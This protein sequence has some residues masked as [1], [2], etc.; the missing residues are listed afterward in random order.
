[1]LAMLRHCCVS[2]LDHDQAVHV[3]GQS[4]IARE[5]E[6][7]IQTDAW[8]REEPALDAIELK[9]IPYDPNA[10]DLCLQYIDDC[11]IRCKQVH[12]FHCVINRARKLL[13]QICYGRVLSFRD[14]PPARNLT[15]LLLLVEQPDPD[16]DWFMEA[17]GERDEES[18]LEESDAADAAPVVAM[19]RKI[20]T[21]AIDERV[22]DIHL[23]PEQARLRR[24]YRI[25]GVLQERPAIAKKYA[26]PVTARLKILA[27]MD[28][29]ERRCPQDGRFT[30]SHPTGRRDLRVSSFPSVW[31]EK[32]VLR[33]LAG[34]GDVVSL[35]LLGFNE[36]SLSRY[37][38]AYTA[39]NGIIL[40]TGPTGSGKSSTLYATLSALQSPALSIVTLEDPVEARIEGITQGQIHARANFSFPEGLRAILRQDPD[41]I[42]V[43]EIRDPET[44]EIAMQASLTGHLVLSTLHTNDAASSV[45]RLLDMEVEPYLITATV[46]CVIAQRLGRR[47]CPTC[48]ELNPIDAKV[49]E[50]LYL[51]EDFIGTKCGARVGCEDC[52]E[53]GYTGRLGIF[54]VMLMD[55]A[56]RR[57]IIK[58]CNR[59]DVED[60]AILGGMCTMRLDGFGKSQAGLTSIDEVLRVT[61]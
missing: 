50:E 45:T 48:R 23:E 58:G 53:T 46:H 14:E 35:E 26:R 40:V 19:V 18:D 13:Q 56:M 32:M 16:T 36:K 59:K 21:E 6:E 54:E 27:G 2:C 8:L 49:V 51:E 60:L 57:E 38:G 52:R 7:A 24:R 30:V 31:G 10:V 29:A 5:I 41:V 17:E 20:V 12:D 34:K 3:C 11:C 37:R 44:A 42:M 33:V 4:I 55:D 9:S 47:L 43:G 61:R 25:D 1:M 28:I 15:E 39:S 22:S